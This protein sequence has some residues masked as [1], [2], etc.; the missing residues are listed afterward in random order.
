DLPIWAFHG[1]L[2]KSIPFEESEQLVNAL[3]AI[4]GNIRF[5]EYPDLGHHEVCALAY[6]NRELYDWLLKQKKKS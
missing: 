2:D 1:R 4:N 6:E 3:K 5:S